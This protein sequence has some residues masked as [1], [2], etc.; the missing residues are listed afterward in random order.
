VEIAPNVIPDLLSGIP[1]RTQTQP[2]V[3]P[4]TT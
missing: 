1:L 4:I 3:Y 2:L